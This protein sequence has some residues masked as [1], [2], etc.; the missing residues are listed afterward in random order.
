MKYPELVPRVER[1]P[2][3]SSPQP[4]SPILPLRG[5][6]RRK[7][8]NLLQHEPESQSCSPQHTQRHPSIKCMLLNAVLFCSNVIAVP[9]GNG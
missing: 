7:A 8:V 3:L 4:Q 6:V 1:P 5:S 9:E 2:R